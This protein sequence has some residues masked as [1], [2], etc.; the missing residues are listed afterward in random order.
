MRHF[1]IGVITI[2]LALF[3]GCNSAKAQ[4]VKR[5]GNTFIVSSNSGVNTSK[6]VATNYSW[7]DK[8]DNEYPIYLHKN[9][10]GEKAGKWVAYVIRQSKKTG[11][12]YK[13]FIP[14]N[15]AITATIVEEMRL[16]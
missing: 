9:I 10:K 15:E 1:I 6:D 4:D 12:E 7:K 11:K 3:A 14:D 2:I 8:N 5:E 16:K 13:Y